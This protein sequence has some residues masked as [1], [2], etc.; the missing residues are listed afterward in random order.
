M[1]YVSTKTFESKTQSGARFVIKKMND[2][3]RRALEELQ[4]PH[5]EF[6]RPLFEEYRPLSEEYLAA[7]SA[8]K[9]VGAAE[10]KAA[11]AGGATEEEA[12]AQF[13]IGKIEFAED[14]FQ[15]W[16][17]LK[18]EIREVERDGLEMAAMRFVVV[19]IDGFEIDGEAA[20][21]EELLADGP[22]DF[23]EEILLEVKRELGLLPDEQ[24]NL[25]LP[26]TSAAAVD[27]KSA[28]GSAAPVEKL[29]TIIPAAA[30]STTDPE[31]ASAAATGDRL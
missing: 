19:R 3:R 5:T 11:I 17:E 31:S 24:E 13:P 14:K 10:R 21:L 30:E 29:V 20:G 26:S 25:S 28:I 16:A 9:S 7:F 6:L 22:D 2:R 18:T 23:R 27:G 12:L 4:A 1:N 15:R 8:A